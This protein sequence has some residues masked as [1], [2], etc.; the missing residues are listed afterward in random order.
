MLIISWSH[1]GTRCPESSPWCGALGAG[2][3][4][5][6]VS[7]SCWTEHPTRLTQRI[8]S[9]RQEEQEG[10]MSE[11]VATSDGIDPAGGALW[12][13][14]RWINRSS[15]QSEWLLTTKLAE[16]QQSNRRRR[17]AAMLN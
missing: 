1:L 13:D 10:Q 7:G 3:S 4:N 16:I 11:R 9:H 17:E 6:R 8:E 15:D 14:D 12:E 2:W 5:Q